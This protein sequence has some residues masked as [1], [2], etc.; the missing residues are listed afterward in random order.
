MT[1]S[2]IVVPALDAPQGGRHVESCGAV[3]TA[4]EFGNRD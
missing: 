3:S 2:L 4:I 1:W